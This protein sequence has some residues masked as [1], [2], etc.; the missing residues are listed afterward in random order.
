MGEYAAQS[1]RVVSIQNQNNWECALAEAAYMTGLERNGDVVR[2]A[3]Y[4]P[5]FA[6]AD[7]W[8]WKPD[9]IWANNLQAYGTPNYYVQQLFSR[10]HGDVLAPA[11]LELAHSAAGTP[12]ETLYASAVRDEATGELILKLINAAVEPQMLD[13]EIQG[14][15]KVGPAGKA[16][17]LTSPRLDD[18][19][20]FE[21][22]RKVA[23]RELSRQIASPQFNEAVPPSSF[24]VLRIP[25]AL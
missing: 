20:S 14:A 3:S 15:K 2:M 23:P 7:A 6:H 19:N 12:R 21:Q 24:L 10:N 4:A 1:D 9:L 5:L 11:V 18:I 13:I 22:P 17:L 8:Q 25:V 16:I